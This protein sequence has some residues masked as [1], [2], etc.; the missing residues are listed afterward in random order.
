MLWKP[1]RV[2]STPRALISLLLQFIACIVI[3]VLFS[4]ISREIIG[5]EVLEYHWISKHRCYCCVCK[6]KEFG[7][8][9]AF[10]VKTPI[11]A[12]GMWF[13]L[14]SFCWTLI[15]WQWFAFVGSVFVFGFF[16]PSKHQV[17]SSLR[18]HRQT[19]KLLYSKTF[20]YAMS[21]VWIC[22]YSSFTVSHPHLSCTKQTSNMGVHHSKQNKQFIFDSE[23]S[24][25]EMKTFCWTQTFK[26][27]CQIKIKTTQHKKKHLEKLLWI[28]KWN[29]I[30]FLMFKTHKETRDMV[31]VCV[32]LSVQHN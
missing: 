3:R 10:I 15:T 16:F 8:W 23:L 28:N 5:K 29:K 20:S 4:R 22:F 18:L 7:Y 32:C 30:K 1:S 11:T 17:A 6:A 26:F 27:K 25:K 2:L 31:C 24:P 9:C 21:N 13:N 14:K 19:N 12:D